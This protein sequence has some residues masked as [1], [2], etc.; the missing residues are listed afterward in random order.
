MYGDAQ[1]TRQGRKD[2]VS[3]VE[4]NFVWCFTELACLL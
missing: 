1:Q 4:F 2:Q 3:S